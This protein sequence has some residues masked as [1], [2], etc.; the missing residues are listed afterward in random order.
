MAGVAYVSAIN[1]V[2][3]PV[4]VREFCYVRPVS[5]LLGYAR[6]STADQDA[7]LQIDALKNAGCYKVFVDQA[8]GSLDERPELSR[9]LDQIRPGDTLVVWRLDRLGRSIRHLIDS[10]TELSGKQ[11]GFRSL[12]ENIDTTTSGGRLIFHIFAALAEFERDLI[13][14]RTQAGLSAARARGRQ[15]GRPPTLSPDQVKT[16][17]RMYEQRDMTVE[18]IGDVL[19]VSRTTIY[20]A[21]RK[22]PSASAAKRR[23]AKA[24]S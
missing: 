4:V 6:V 16:A 9:L 1:S 8:S 17:R 14:E 7:A 20:R 3:N 2:A 13:R 5:A 22:Q 24:A 21:L 23:A 15:G 18:Q 12:T 11:I 19:G 10:L